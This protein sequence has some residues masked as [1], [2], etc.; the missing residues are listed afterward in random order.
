MNNTDP[1]QDLDKVFFSS[2]QEALSHCPKGA[3]EGDDLVDVVVEKNKIFRD[4]LKINP[5]LDLG[6]A[7]SLMGLAFTNSNH[8]RVL[9][10][11]GGGGYHYTIARLALPRETDISWAVVE[12][13]AMVKKAKS[14]EDGS[15]VFFD[16]IAKAISY[17]EDVD[18]VFTSGALQC[19]ADPIG[20]LS[21]LLK[22][23]AK[24]VFITRTAFNH[25]NERLIIR[26][27]SRLSEH[28]PGLL[29]ERFTDRDVFCPNVFEPLSAIENII[30]LNG[31]QIRYRVFEGPSYNGKNGPIHMFG[32]L[33]ELHN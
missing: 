20:F 12:T 23:Q 29:P 8:L 5:S 19:C 6:A 15:L 22:V 7:R 9:D 26:Q 33:A 21:I 3:Y 32:Y 16:E 27:R 11:G 28:G 13:P 10:F 25:E 24:R 4:Q 1:T 30:A 18:I 31:Y 17:L 2:Y 14:L